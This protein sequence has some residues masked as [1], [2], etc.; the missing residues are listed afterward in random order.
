MEY[1]ETKKRPGTTASTECTT[2]PMAG[3]WINPLSREGLGFSSPEG[4]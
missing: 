4:R 3:G 1:V 2:V